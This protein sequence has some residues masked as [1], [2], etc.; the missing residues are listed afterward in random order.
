MSCAK[1]IETLIKSIVLK[2]QEYWIISIVWKNT[3]KSPVVIHM[4]KVNIGL[5]VC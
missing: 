5:H 4:T 1:I 2:D 3:F